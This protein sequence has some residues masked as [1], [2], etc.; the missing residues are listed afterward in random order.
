M[1]ETQGGQ[2]G[3]ASAGRSRWT[4]IFMVVLGAVAAVI[5]VVLLL[6]PGEQASFGW[7]AYQPLSNTTF[8]PSGELLTPL[9][10]IGIALLAVG[11]ASLSFGAGWMFG[12]RHGAGQQRLP[13]PGSPDA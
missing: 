10:Q 13:D 5:G 12:R 1:G 11:V 6:V 8:I 9:R 2:G 7:F 4:S 3:S